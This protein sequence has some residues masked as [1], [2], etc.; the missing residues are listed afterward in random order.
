M[1]N[2]NHE[3]V[4]L[5]EE[6]R[7]STGSKKEGCKEKELMGKIRDLKVKMSS[8]RREI[9]SNKAQPPTKRRKTGPETYKRVE[10][11]G[12]KAMKRQLKEKEEPTGIQKWLKK[13]KDT[14]KEEEDDERDAEKMEDRAIPTGKEEKAPLAEKKEENQLRE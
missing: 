5:G 13:K 2:I 9:N 7:S 8:S 12:R 3:G 11:D 10:M 14:P 6:E 1:L 4:K